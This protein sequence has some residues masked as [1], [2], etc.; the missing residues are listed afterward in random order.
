MTH[1]NSDL[2]KVFAENL[3]SLSERRTSIAQ[4][5]REIGI[6]RQQFN[7]YL[8]GNSLPSQLW[9]QR[10]SGYF[11]VSVSDLF[12]TDN[13]K[14]DI[15]AHAKLDRRKDA[16]CTDE[17]NIVSY[18]IPKKYHGYYMIY[19]R[20]SDNSINK[21]VMFVAERNNETYFHIRF[22]KEKS[23]MGRS[24]G[25]ALFI[26]DRLLFTGLSVVDLSE[27][28]FTM[29]V[30]PSP[31]P[32]IDMLSGIVTGTRAAATK[33]ITSCAVAI[34]YLGP[35]VNLYNVV[36]SAGNAGLDDPSLN[37]SIRQYFEAMG[38]YEIAPLV[39]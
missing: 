6:N 35:S 26:G 18:C 10:I 24:S 25:K 21:W 37:P 36:R 14:P 22:Y 27:Y 32:K 34:E 23:Q 19:R 33:P 3:R 16:A 38:P 29:L 30:Y 39:L 12:S 5:C 15:V 28:V 31:A 1:R 17:K 11:S 8:S 9:M 4:I 13:Q 7:K 20:V 2:R